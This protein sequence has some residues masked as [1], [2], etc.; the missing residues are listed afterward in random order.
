[1]KSLSG[2][3]TEQNLRDAF[4]G[5]C[6]ATNKYRYYASKARKDGYMQIAEL[7]QETSDNELEHAKIWFKYLHDG[8]VPDTKVNLEDAAEG[9]MFEWTEMYKRM[10]EEARA[11]G[12]DEIA[13]HFELVGNVEKQHEER[14]RKLLS[15]VKE[16]IVFSREN[17]MIWQCR[18]CGHIVIGK[19][20]PLVCPVCNHPQSYFQIK[21]E[22]Y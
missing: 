19:N 12:F 22:N 16:G 20:A 18:N 17:D 3:K 6:Q 5:E 4:S 8:S 13:E 7:F 9:E 11:E 2:T 14:Y 21:A 15:N 1:M 10:A